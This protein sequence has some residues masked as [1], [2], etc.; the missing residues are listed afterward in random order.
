MTSSITITSQ[1]QYPK[2]T[3]KLSGLPSKRIMRKKYHNKKGKHIIH[4]LQWSDR[5][6]IN[7][8]YYT[9]INTN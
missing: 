1:A 4:L 5:A 2:L 9:E 8:D 3:T 7:C 6:Q